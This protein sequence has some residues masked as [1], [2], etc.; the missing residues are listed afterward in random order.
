MGSLFFEPEEGT[1]ALLLLEFHFET[2]ARHDSR[3]AAP[4]RF[5][6]QIDAVHIKAWTDLLDL[7]FVARQLLL[8]QQF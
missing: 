1:D 7:P 2:A 8:E 3:V 4:A 5:M 6:I